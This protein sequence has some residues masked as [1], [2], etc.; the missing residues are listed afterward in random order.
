[1]CNK[2]LKTAFVAALTF[3]VMDCWG[4]PFAV[5]GVGGPQNQPDPTAVTDSIV[6][7]TLSEVSSV[8]NIDVGGQSF[9]GQE[10]IKNNKVNNVEIAFKLRFNTSKVKLSVT[11]AAMLTCENASKT[12]ECF[13]LKLDIYGNASDAIGSITTSN[14]SVDLEAD[15]FDSTDNGNNIKIKIS[16]T[17][18]GNTAFSDEGIF[19]LKEG[20][21]N[22][23]I[24]ID[25]RAI[26]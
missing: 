24:T 19:K 1:M 12:G 25:L 8:L 23:D 18:D 3:G 22:K 13:Y 20:R 5:P 11:D 21:Y 15:K 2:F 10:L 6:V 7:G 16:P 17:F 4:M 14:L 26:D 9:K